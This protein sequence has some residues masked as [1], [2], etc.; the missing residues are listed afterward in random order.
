MMANSADALTALVQMGVLEIHP[1]GSTAKSQGCPDRIIFDIDPGEGVEWA[2]VA[3]SAR[4]VRTLLEGLGLRS[5]LKTTGGKGLHVVAPL[6]PRVAWD[7]VK[8]FS[9]A[10]AD[11]FARTFPDRFVSNMSKAK[12]RGKIFIDYLRNAEGAT[13]VCAYSTRARENAPVAVP[14][15]WKELGSEDVRFDH[16]HIGNVPQ[17]LARLK[18]DPWEGFFE[19]RQSVTAKMMKEVG[20][21]K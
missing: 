15:A 12:R 20:Y 6:Q 1:W 18:S 4:D 3:Q 17:R 9:K 5:Y 21:K 19:V 14:L 13:A 7:E 11:L 16:F 2:E 10:I 8:G